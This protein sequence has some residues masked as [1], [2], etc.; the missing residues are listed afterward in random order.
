MRKRWM[1]R[2]SGAA[3][4]AVFAA[5]AMTGAACEKETPAAHPGARAKADTPRTVRVV[6]AAEA[7]L[8]RTV[9]VTGTL[10]ADEEV[11]AGFKVAGRV[12]E[13][14]VD[15]GSPVRKGQ[16]LARLDPTDFR[17]RVEQAEA[18][19]R[20]VRAGLGLPPEGADDRVDPDKTALVREARAVLGEAGLNRDRMAMLREKDLV[21]RAEFD[22]AVS[23]L[24][25]AESRYQAAVEEVR[26]RQELL[27][28]RRSALSLARQQ[29]A[30]AVLH[31]PIDG[32]VRERRA[33]VGEYLA[34]GAPVVRLVRIHPLRLRVAVPERDAPS[35]RAGQAVK[36]RL[37]GD[38][39]EHAGR[40]VR[41]SPAIQEQNRTLVVEAEVANRDGRLRPGAFAKAEIVVDADRSAVLVPA[42]SVVTFAGIEKVFGV[43]DGRAVEMRIRTG[44]HVGERVEVLEG[45]PPGVPVVVEPGS[46]I[47]GQAVVVTK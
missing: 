14:A 21:A 6:E 26:N 19:L 2:G 4:L 3:A 8:P 27:A 12:S 13:I 5:I 39:A 45:L 47:G 37:E 31:A 35:I 20:Q 16:V 28:E 30:D 25:V 46:I 15:L 32:A 23:R 10:A 38:P 42:R 43:K 36:V 17:I 9:T 33:S 29:L 44:R 7:R 11:V 1:S 41:L 18:A 34:A 22:A 24:L 40:V